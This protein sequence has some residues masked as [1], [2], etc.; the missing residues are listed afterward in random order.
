MSQQGY[1]AFRKRFLPV[2]FAAVL[3]PDPLLAGAVRSNAIE[4][5]SPLTA[6]DG[7]EAVNISGVSC[8]PLVDG[9]YVCLAIDDEG[10]RAQ[11]LTIEGSRL[12]PGGKIPIFGK[13]APPG[14]VGSKPQTDACSKGE[15]KFKDLDGEAVA[16]DGKAFYIV[17]SHGCSRHGNKFRASSFVLARV[18]REV[19]VAAST[20]DPG[21]VN[22]GTEVA[23]TYR[24][25]EAL[26]VAP[27]AKNF[28]SKDLM[29]ANGLNIEGL[30]IVDGTLYAGLRAPIVD[31]QVYLVAIKAETLFDPKRPIV[32]GDVKEIPLALGRDKGIRDLALLPD[33]RIL[34]LSGPAQDAAVAFALY[35]VDPK[36][37]WKPGQVAVLDD[38]PPVGSDTK[39]EALHVFGQSGKTLDLLIMFDGPKSGGPRRYSVDLE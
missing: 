12:T 8:L 4:V 24:L 23:T 2:A 37:G 34:I 28:F 1:H 10:R 38:F 14:I 13:A 30:V 7:T 15:D 25:S 26:L 9:K 3:M 18:A 33:G 21:V 39:A 11:T 31:D 17:G 29:T 27:R 5:A 32:E 20:A 19:V 6:D 16:N 22:D 36:A 35:V